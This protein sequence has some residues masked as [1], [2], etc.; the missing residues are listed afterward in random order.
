MSSGDR[1]QPPVSRRRFFAWS[2]S[3]AAGIILL[4]VVDPARANEESRAGQRAVDSAARPP[5]TAGSRSGAV[6]GS[7]GEAAS[8]TIGTAAVPVPTAV[9]V[10]AAPAHRIHELRPDAPASAIALTIDDG[11]HPVWT[12]RIL[13]VLR[14]NRVSAT[15]SLVGA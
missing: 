7:A 4:T 15:F 11:P 2:A 5:G 6:R 13:E 3:S 8:G 9:P 1:P 12:P 10:P 14:V